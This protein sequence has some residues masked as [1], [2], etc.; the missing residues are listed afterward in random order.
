LSILT[1][2]TPHPPQTTPFIASSINTT[3]AANP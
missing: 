2:L 3:M 1:S